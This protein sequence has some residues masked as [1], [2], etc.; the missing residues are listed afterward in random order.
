MKAVV[1]MLMLDNTQ[2]FF[3][4]RLPLTSTRL[5]TKHMYF[6]LDMLMLYFLWTCNLVE[7]HAGLFGW[8]VA[9]PLILV[10]YWG[11]RRYSTYFAVCVAICALAKEHSIRDL[12]GY[13]AVYYVMHGTVI[14]GAINDLAVDTLLNKRVMGMDKQPT[15]IKRFACM[16]TV[17]TVSTC[18]FGVQFTRLACLWLLT[19]MGS[20]WIRGR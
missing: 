9:Y 4:S 11:V 19:V 7:I 3:Y 6:M 8:Y 20:M 12:E 18:V 15:D 14:L 13:D 17:V 10:Y 5:K 16:V 1:T 2:W